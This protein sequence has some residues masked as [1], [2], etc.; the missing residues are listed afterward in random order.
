MTNRFKIGDRVVLV[1]PRGTLAGYCG[2]EATV[3]DLFSTG[4]E[5]TL[6]VEWVEDN[7]LSPHVWENQFDHVGGP[8]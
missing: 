8:W 6:Y 2:Q 3:T 5:P 1:R 7:R 4:G